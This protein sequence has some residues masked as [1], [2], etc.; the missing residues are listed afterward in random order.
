ME[1]IC[2]YCKKENGQCYSHKKGDI[3]FCLFCGE[4]GI[5]TRKKGVRKYSNKEKAGTKNDNKEIDSR[6]W[7]PRILKDDIY[8]T[9]VLF[10]DGDFTGIHP[11]HFHETTRFFKLLFHK[12]GYMPSFGDEVWSDSESARGEQRF[13]IVGKGFG[14][15]DYDEILLYVIPE[16]DW[17]QKLINSINQTNK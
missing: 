12:I 7:L 11:N 2:P 6:D 9:V 8:F 13:Y 17:K 3:F 14:V 4:R 10:K 1:L 15:D 16:E 5:L